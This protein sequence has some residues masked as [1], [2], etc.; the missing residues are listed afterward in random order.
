ML[1]I[2]VYGSLCIFLIFNYIELK[3]KG[4]YFV[5]LCYFELNID[6]EYYNNIGIC[7]F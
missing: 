6:F 7:N 2:F 4:M 1:L 5:V 3:E